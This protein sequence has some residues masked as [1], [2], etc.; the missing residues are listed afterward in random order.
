MNREPINFATLPREVSTVVAALTHL[1]EDVVEWAC[2]THNY[3]KLVYT[4]RRLI[5]AEH[6]A[7]H[8][9]LFASFITYAHQKFGAA[10]GLS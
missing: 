3:D 5:D 4:A 2:R 1:P 6:V 10:K 8:P 9:R 7:E